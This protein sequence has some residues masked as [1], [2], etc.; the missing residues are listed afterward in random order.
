MYCGLCANIADRRMSAGGET[1]TENASKNANGK[2]LKKALEIREG[3]TSAY[4]CYTLY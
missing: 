3:L 1:L 4:C 2:T